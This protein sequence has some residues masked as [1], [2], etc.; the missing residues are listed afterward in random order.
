VI[1]VALKPKGSLWDIAFWRARIPS[2][3]QRRPESGSKWD[4]IPIGK[5]AHRN[6]FCVG[7]NIYLPCNMLFL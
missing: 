2:T 6:M 1:G 7:L 5:I 4:N 3:Y